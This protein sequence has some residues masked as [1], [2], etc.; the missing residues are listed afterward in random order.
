MS[1]FQNTAFR[2]PDDGLQLIWDDVLL[3]VSRDDKTGLPAA[4]DRQTLEAT[5]SF[6][7]KLMKVLHPF[8]PFITEEICIS[9]RHTKDC[10]T[11]PL[12]RD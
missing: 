12:C 5:L 10:I 1:I 9:E 8:M 4:C 7:E 11:M 3:M 2:N 6:F